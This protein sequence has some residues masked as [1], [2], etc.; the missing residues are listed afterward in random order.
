MKRLF[1]LFALLPAS[2]FSQS[3]SEWMPA[4]SYPSANWTN[5]QY[6][7]ASDDNYCSRA[8]GGGTFDSQI[9]DGFEFNLPVDAIVS[10][11]RVRI[12]HHN[13]NLE[14]DVRISIR[15][16]GGNSPSRLSVNVDVT[17]AT[18]YVGASDNIWGFSSISGAEIN[19]SFQVTVYQYYIGTVTTEYVDFLEAR[20]W[21]TVPSSG[22]PH[23]VNTVSRYCSINTVSTSSI[24]SINSVH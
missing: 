15:I 9:W 7:Y 5:P 19:D 8:K 17:D 13:S 18:Y 12:E 24:N 10:G 6:A 3:F 2:I 4:T 22:F 1:L 21:Y 16:N 23:A 11:I 14:A 20:I